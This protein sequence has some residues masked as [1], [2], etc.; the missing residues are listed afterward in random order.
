[1]NKIRLLGINV[2]CLSM[3][4]A[5]DVIGKFIEEKTPRHVVTA[6]ASMIVI[7]SEDK[8]L[9]SIIENADL[10]TP[11]GAGLVWASK[12]LGEPITQRVSGVDLV[13]NLCDLSRTK[14]WSL[15][16]L[17]SAPGVADDAAANLRIKYPGCN[18]VGVRHG[19]FKEDEE[20]AIAAEIREKNPDILLVAFG[21]PKQEKFIVRRKKSMQVPVSIGIGGSFDVYSGRVKRAP[22]W[23]QRMS[24]EWLFRLWQN[25]KKLSKVMTLPRFVGM[26]LKAKWGSGSR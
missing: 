19:F 21:I 18:I 25:P 12:L 14:G 22:L 17:G 15:F 8:E 20:P 9:A 7:A 1:M 24:L 4:E 11:D 6:D 2:D 5:L 13:G 16:F 10:V 23:M 3:S 26:A